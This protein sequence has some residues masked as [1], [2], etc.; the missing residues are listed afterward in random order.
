MLTATTAPTQSATDLSPTAPFKPGSLRT[1]LDLLRDPVRTLVLVKARQAGLTLRDVSLRLDKAQGYMSVYMTKGFPGELSAE[2]RA[3]LAPML[4]VDEDQ[5]VR[6][7]GAILALESLAAR[8]T[9]YV[10]TV[11]LYTDLERLD[12]P[13]QAK[14]LIARPLA[15]STDVTGMVAVTMT[16]LDT[17]RVRLGDT[18]YLSPVLPHSGDLAAVITVTGYL[19]RI[20]EIMLIE[21]IGTLGQYRIAWWASPSGTYYETALGTTLRKVVA[22]F[23]R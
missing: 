10:P 15:T 20:D 13:A 1:P 16:E 3:V 22:I 6:R 19:E 5:L 21:P 11:P 8:P 17:D 4:D 7:T 2:V 23:P 18:V 9:S 12:D 14:R